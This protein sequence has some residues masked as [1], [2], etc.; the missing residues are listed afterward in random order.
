MLKRRLLIHVVPLIA[1]VSGLALPM[2]RAF[3]CTL[4]LGG[5]PEYSLE[6]LVNNAPIVFEGTVVANLG[7]SEGQYD[8]QVQVIE[9]LKGSADPVVKIG[10]FGTSALC[11]TYVYPGET[12]IF[13]AAG[14]GAELRAYYL[15]QGAAV[16]PS[17]PEALAA[18]RAIV[19]VPTETPVVNPPQEPREDLFPAAWL[20]ASLAFMTVGGAGMVGY[21]IK[22]KSM[23]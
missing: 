9:Y 15:V 2:Q 22:R 18:I 12:W 21:L 11:L 17:S 3:A 19:G 14:S 7:P 6:D 5:L 20:C 8:V 4:P 10:S 23:A 1:L 13:F 16:T